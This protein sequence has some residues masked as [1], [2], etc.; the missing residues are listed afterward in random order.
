MSKKLNANKE[1]NKKDIPSKIY[2]FRKWI[3]I[4]MFLLFIII[5]IPTAYLI[6]YSKTKITPFESTEHTTIS[7]FSKIEDFKFDFYCSSYG[8]KDDTEDSKALVFKYSISDFDTT[9]YGYSAIKISVAIGDRHWTNNYYEGSS[10]TIYSGS[11]SQTSSK[12]G[13]YTSLG[14]YTYQYPQSKWG[15]IK[16][17]HPTV[18]VLLSYNKTKSSST[19]TINY[20]VSL[21]YSKWFR[22]GE[23]K[24]I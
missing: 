7:S 5:L 16:V 17:S 11:V 19:K 6:E 22:S 12:T 10:S 13:T 18:W 9:S 1:K 20:M 4:G 21:S 2:K 3:I 15:I 24:I 8:E 14:S 23:T